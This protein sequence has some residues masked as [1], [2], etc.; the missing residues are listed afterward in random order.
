[1]ST[2]QSMIE[3]IYQLMN[4]GKNLSGGVVGA[5]G[6][7]A[8]GLGYRITRP[9]LADPLAFTTV[10][11][12]TGAI[13]ITLLMAYRTIIQAAGAS[14]INFQHTE[15]PTA[16]DNAAG[17]TTGDDVNTLYICPLAAATPVAVG[18]NGAPI[19][20]AAN[21]FAGPGNIQVIHGAGTGSCLY[22]LCWIPLTSNATV[23]AV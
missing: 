23:V 18:V 2:N 19:I 10:F 7:M 3:A 20:G 15:G 9:S 22:T 1:M 12:I 5:T 4:G 21:I 14:T 8:G 6:G 17:A 11:T 16:L 13:Q